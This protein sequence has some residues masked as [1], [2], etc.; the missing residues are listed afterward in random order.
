MAWQFNPSFET[1][2]LVTVASDISRYGGHY[3]FSSPSG[4]AFFNRA[5]EEFL[6]PN[7][8]GWLSLTGSICRDYI[9]DRFILSVQGVKPNFE[10]FTSS[11]VIESSKLRNNGL[12]ELRNGV[13]WLVDELNGTHRNHLPKSP[14]PSSAMIEPSGER[15]IILD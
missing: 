7:L 15:Q 11:R 13:E 10:T 3:G 8:N 12:E 9:A 14:A 1:G 5:I 6:K 2:S 4:E